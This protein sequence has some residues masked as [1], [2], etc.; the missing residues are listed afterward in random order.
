MEDVE[1]NELVKQFQA[2]QK[3]QIADQITERNV[4][5]IVN[6]LLRKKMI[7][8]LYTTDA[9]EYM[10]WDELKREVV[11]EVH[12]NGGRINVVDIPGLL[13]VHT[14]HVERVLP[15]ILA[16]DPT[17]HL[18]GGELMT[19]QYL[20]TAVQTAGDALK[21]HGSLSVAQ[22][23]TKYQFTSAFALGLLTNAMNDGR[24]SAVIQDSALYTKQFVR[25]QRLILRAGLLAA[26][27]TVDV[28]ALYKRHGLFSPLMETLIRQLSEE[29]PGSFHG[30]V[31]TPKV[32]DVFRAEQVHNIYA[33]NGVIA[34][35]SLQSMGITNAKQYLV[36]R[37]N[38]SSG[39]AD[40][41]PTTATASAP[42][43]TGGGGGRKGGKRRAAG[44]GAAH[45]PAASAV[46]IVRADE[47]HPL[48]GYPLSACFLSDKYLN[49]LAGLSPLLEGDALALD[50][51]Q[52]FPVG[53]DLAKD[54]AAL[55]PRLVELYPGV[56]SCDLIEDAVLLRRDAAETVRP[57]LLE[58]LKAEPT[59]GA[60]KK[61]HKKSGGD[62][63]G[64]ASPAAD[65]PIILKTVA[66]ALKLTAEH[67]H[68][69]VREVVE[70]W[71]AMIEEILQDVEAA[72]KN[73]AAA[74]LKQSR[75]T[76]QTSLTNAWVELGVI[77]KGLQWAK[78]QL[79]EA[80]YVALCRHTLA[81][82]GLSVCRDVVLNESLDLP[83]VNN[84]VVSALQ[85]ST[86]L[87]NFKNCLAPFPDKLR[88]SLL[89]IANA[90]NEKELAPLLDVLQD[91]SSTGVI[92]VSSFY[93]PNKKTERE[94]NSKMKER[95]DTVIRSSSFS[96]D[97]AANG[98][99]F[100]SLT[101]LLVLN[102]FRAYVEIPGK[103]VG[104]VVSRLTREAEAPASLVEALGIVTASL[105]SGSV[106]A[107]Q[108][109]A[110]EQLRSSILPAE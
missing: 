2:L 35:T 54:W 34:Y 25:S 74:E 26:E 105:Q 40:D 85:Q 16:A 62:S 22:F 60:G 8:L 82:R 31:Y 55:V 88:E 90:L 10:T 9:K 44:G 30:H 93:A 84:N 98:A 52:L 6:T 75:A 12:A 100:A 53:V 89:P 49:N 29:L 96:E 7:D 97:V 76:L 87:G 37:Y 110:L 39:S 67:Y 73:R 72:K 3:E 17:L 56:A 65:A 47:G 102:L 70:Q 91:M 79:D 59:V 43:N 57:Q 81:T 21:E 4:V 14:Y 66:K 64:S 1:L 19:D 11:D 99:L 95:L 92:A 24:L 71:S 18:E 45:T 42:A 86:T 41:G 104:G 27:Q 36:N 106:D 77:G 28:E 109:M 94:A 51:T 32:F 78:G 15:D 20:E 13:S 107:S 50:A 83:E 23:A 69:V 48:C 61:G 63:S 38:P 108:V 58:A 33:S 101:S 46:P 80:T 103:A 5:E 68:D